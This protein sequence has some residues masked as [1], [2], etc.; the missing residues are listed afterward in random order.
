MK[1][2]K[3]TVPPQSNVQSSLSLPSDKLERLQDRLISLRK[4]PADKLLSAIRT[5]LLEPDSEESA[6]SIKSK[7]CSKEDT[8]PQFISSVLNQLEKAID[9]HDEYE[10]KM[11][12][13]EIKL[14]EKIQAMRETHF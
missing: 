2:D 5:Q 14:K 9:E 13:R 3:V 8:I 4:K 6:D 11:E 1:L 7:T 10:E 12:E